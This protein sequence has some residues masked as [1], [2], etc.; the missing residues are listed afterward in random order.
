MESKHSDFL[1]KR[2]L[3][4][5]AHH[6]VNARFDKERRQTRGRKSKDRTVSTSRSQKT[7]SLSQNRKMQRKDQPKLK[8]K[9]NLF[10][11]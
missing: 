1:P 3:D 6:S 8:Q 7:I 2:T 4:K 5:N 11:S 9:S 10:V